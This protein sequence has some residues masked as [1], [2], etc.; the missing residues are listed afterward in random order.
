MM[1]TKRILDKGKIKGFVGNFNELFE[2]VVKAYIK[3]AVQIRTRREYLFKRYPEIFNDSSKN[4]VEMD[5]DKGKTRPKKP[6]LAEIREKS[7]YKRCCANK[8]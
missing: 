6:N 5:I 3:D 1:N 4:K 7:I 8:N 2:N